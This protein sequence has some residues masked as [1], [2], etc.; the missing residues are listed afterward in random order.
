[1]TPSK[2]LFFLCVSFVAGIFLELII[3]IP[4]IFIWAFLFADLLAIVVFLLIKKDILIIAGFCF[5]FLIMAIL[6]VQISEFNIANDKLSKLNDK[7]Q[8][9]LTG[10]IS[11]EPD[12][13]DASQKIKVKVADSIIL[14]TTNIY[15][16]YKYLDKIKLTG[17]LE[18]PMAADD[19]NYKNYLLPQ[20][21]YSVMSFPKIELVSTEHQYNIFS[22]SYEKIL[23]LKQGLRQS[24][25]N[26][27]LPP[28]SSI[29]QG[30]ILGD[31]GAMSQD[32][33]NKLSVTGLRHFIAISGLHIVIL[34]SIVMSFLL[35]IGM[36][37]NK[38][39][40]ITIIFICTYI[41]L[42]GASAAALRAGIMGGT[43]L[44]AQKF[45][46][47]AF[48]FRIVALAA[49]LI[50][51]ANPLLLFYDVGFQL[52]FLAVLG[53]IYF[54]P[55]VRNFIKFLIKKFLN[56]KIAEK[57][58]SALMLVSVTFAAQ[59]FTLPIV[60]FN[61]GNISWVFP[62][63]NILILPIFYYLMLF[64][65]LSSLVGIFW[66]ALGWLLSVPCYF[67]LLYFM[68]VVNFFS[69]PQMTKTITNVSWVWLLFSYIIIGFF[70]WF[71]NKK[72]S[73][74]F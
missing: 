51:L 62:I 27:F 67:L 71:L 54:E 50:L 56:I 7:G 25:Q 63:A 34:I 19:F 20:H 47:Q 42:T 74:I 32:L 2:I 39:F 59:I 69:Q 1:M 61:F 33:K 23:F 29:L 55:L 70:T 22:W 13:R 49:A 28:Q 35:A 64:G 4:Q 9:V 37:R 44:L 53:L 72:Y 16:E 40:Y 31:N 41:I 6:R 73:R 43:Y 57:H 10:I 17:K 26:N 60:V 8:V 24:I 18:T 58:E 5:L 48:S 46:R 68:W 11:D 38:A 21:I 12:V 3:K 36:W 65:F 30:T 15:P 45:G 14:A 52:S 66:S